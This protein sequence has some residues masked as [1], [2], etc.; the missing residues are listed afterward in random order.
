MVDWRD[1]GVG[2]FVLLFMLSELMR[3]ERLES[4]EPYDAARLGD[5][6]LVAGESN[7]DPYR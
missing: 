7:P 5:G 3:E 2:E 6:V 1:S 4:I